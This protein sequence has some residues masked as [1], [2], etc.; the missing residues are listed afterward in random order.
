MAGGG[1]Q[2]ERRFLRRPAAAARAPHPRRGRAPPARPAPGPRG[3]VRPPSSL[4]GRHRGR[5]RSGAAGGRPPPRWLRIRFRAGPGASPS[6]R[7]SVCAPPSRPRVCLKD[8]SEGGKLSRWQQREQGGDERA[9]PGFLEARE[10]GAS[11][12]VGR[13]TSPLAPSPRSLRGRG[14]RA[15][16]PGESEPRKPPKWR[17]Q[18]GRPF[19]DRRAA[20]PPPSRPGFPLEVTGARLRSDPRARRGAGSCPPGGHSRGGRRGR[21]ESRRRHRLWRRR[22]GRSAT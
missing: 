8:L 9:G 19:A 20:R 14:W 15:P 22:R 16:R 3:I 2:A 17:L 10:L 6:L 18:P 11:C 1:A 7:A 4:R 13:F 5:R 21:R 12:P